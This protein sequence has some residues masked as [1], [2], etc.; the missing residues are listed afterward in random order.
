MPLHTFLSS[1]H[2]IPEFRLI[3]NFPISCT[4]SKLQSPFEILPSLLEILLSARNHPELQTSLHL[5]FLIM[6]LFCQFQVFLHKKF[7]LVAI[8]GEVSCTDSSDI[9]HGD[10]LT[11][12]IRHLNRM[13][14]CVL[15]VVDRVFGVTQT[16]IAEPE[17]DRS[18]EFSIYICKRLM[19]FVI[20]DCFFCILW[21][22]LA[23]ELIVNSYT[24]VS[25]R[26]SVTIIDR[27]ADLQKFQIV[28]YSFVMFVNIVI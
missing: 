27:F 20:L 6:H 22:F 4:F 2:R 24:I 21:V 25:K 9:S 7:H 10:W 14:K 3:I 16:I 11:C 26:L 28:L 13:F 19:Q 15:E 12:E 8:L 1:Y 17:V 5:T 23:D 18:Q